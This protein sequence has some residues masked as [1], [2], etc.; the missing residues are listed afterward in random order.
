MPAAEHS[1]GAQHLLAAFIRYL[2]YSRE[3]CH[4][5]VN[6]LQKHVQACKQL[7]QKQ[8]S[9]RRVRL[10]AASRKAIKYCDKLS[11]LM[12]LSYNIPFAALAGQAVTIMLGSSV[13]R[14]REV[15][16]F[17]FPATMD[18]PGRAPPS[19]KQL[20]EASRQLMRTLIMQ[21][22]NVTE[23]DDTPGPTKMFLLFQCPEGSIPT[24]PE[25][26]MAKRAFNINLRK[27][28]QVNIDL[29]PSCPRLCDADQMCCDSG[30]N[31]LELRRLSQQMS[32]SMQITDAVAHDTSPAAAAPAGVWYQCVVHVK[33]LRPLSTDQ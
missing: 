1:A 2:V 20:G 17:I 23:W 15:Y 7:Q 27:A 9:G 4:A 3:Q 5:P 22:S 6:D 10:K 16:S 31:D 21:H 28:F 18:P 32:T 26:F 33:G 24:A 30:D 14:P 19:E 29:D 13:T 11:S 8:Q 12:Q 25:G